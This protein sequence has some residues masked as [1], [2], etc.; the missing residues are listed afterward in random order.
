MLLVGQH[1]QKHCSNKFEKLGQVLEVAV[2][3]SRPH[4]WKW[5]SWK[6]LRKVVAM[7]LMVVVVMSVIS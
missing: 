6:K 4:Y 7:L 3:W 2:N 1:C 5:V